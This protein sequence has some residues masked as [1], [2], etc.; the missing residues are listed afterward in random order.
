[1]NLFDQP[2]GAAVGIRYEP[3]HR[4][5]DHLGI[6]IDKILFTKDSPF[7]PKFF[8]LVATDFNSRTLHN[9]DTED[10]LS[11]SQTDLI[12]AVNSLTSF[13]SIEKFGKD[14]YD[15]AFQS[16]LKEARIENIIRYGCVL[17]YA[18]TA[19]DLKTQLPSVF[20]SQFEP[21]KE[22]NLG[23]SKQFP[24]EESIIKKDVNDYHK[25]IFQITQNTVGKIM[26]T[27]DFQRIFDPSL[28]SD[29]FKDHP[30]TTFIQEAQRQI[31]HRG[32][33]YF[34]GLLKDKAA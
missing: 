13:E 17:R 22:F 20:L 3:Q 30:F 23:I 4:V 11:V 7:V 32:L 28:K 12:L 27:L 14:F 19:D 33:K 31:N 15:F 5:A 8:P 24:I 1:M 6:I 18:A 25:L 16:L 26:I 2:S 10:F 34:V 29:D 21:V 9:S